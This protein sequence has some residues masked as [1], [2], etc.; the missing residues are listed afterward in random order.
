MVISTRPLW[1]LRTPYAKIRN[2]TP[3]ASCHL[4]LSHSLRSSI[5]PPFNE[6]SY[7]HTHTSIFFQKSGSDVL[8]RTFTVEAEIV[9]TS[10][11][12]LIKRSRVSSLTSLA[13]QINHLDR[14]CSNLNTHVCVCISTVRWLCILE[15]QYSGQK[16][17]MHTHHLPPLTC[18]KQTTVSQ[19]R[20]HAWPLTCSKSLPLLSGI[21]DQCRIQ[22]VPCPLP[23]RLHQMIT[24]T[25][26]EIGKRGP[27]GLCY[28]LVHR[29][30]KG[31]KVVE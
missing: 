27:D 18:F 29:L 25:P 24:R 17:S 4:S 21:V 12:W 31:K 3:F 8:D 19:H 16:V 9:A 6:T 1:K 23:Q 5:V 15:I 20:E 10:R 2:R 7:T 11:T 13:L 30:G 14:Y 22:R 28:Q 26:E